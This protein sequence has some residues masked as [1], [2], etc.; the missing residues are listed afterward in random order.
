MDIRS[1]LSRIQLA[2][3]APKGERNDFA[4][5][6]YRTAEGILSAVK[7]L[8]NGLTITLSD[9]IEMIGERFYIKSTATLSSE[10]ESIK[11]TVWDR[12]CQN[13]KGMDE[14]QITGSVSSYARKYAL[15]GLFATDDTPDP[16]S[17]DNSNVRTSSEK[18]KYPTQTDND[19]V[20][21]IK[22]GGSKIEDI[23]D[24]QYR[25]YIKGLI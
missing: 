15:N 19:W 9:E 16:D 17:M 3:K 12:E 13:K 18:V 10:K 23:N 1:E 7:P 4:N 20:D 24:I 11:V 5:F 14:A 2:L 22:S 25:D 6:N 21:S 8:L